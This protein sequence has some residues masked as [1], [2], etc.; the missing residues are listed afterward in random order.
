MFEKIKEIIAFPGTPVGA[1]AAMLVVDGILHKMQ[2]YTLSYVICA[3]LFVVMLLSAIAN[4]RDYGKFMK[5]TCLILCVFTALFMITEFPDNGNSAQS[6]VTYGQQNTGSHYSGYSA[7]SSYYYDFDDDYDFEDD[8][9][10]MECT[11]CYGSGKCEDCGGSGK[12]K[13]TGVLAAG[14]C[15]LCDASGRCYKCDGKGYTVHY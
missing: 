15:A 12:S 1:F 10:T 11:R 13:L 3:I 6:N 14:G 5:Y 4:Y 7:G 2:A 8:T 9:F